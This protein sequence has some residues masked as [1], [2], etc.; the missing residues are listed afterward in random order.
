MTQRS[1]RHFFSSNMG[2]RGIP[3]YIFID[4]E[5]VSQVQ[6]QVNPGIPEWRLHELLLKEVRGRR[7]VQK[8]FVS[9]NL[10]RGKVRPQGVVSA[11]PTIYVLQGL[12]KDVTWCGTDAVEDQSVAGFP[13][14]PEEKKG[15]IDAHLFRQARTKQD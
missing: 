15:Y 7:Q 12:P 13:D 5:L 1:W 14:L 3:T 10:P 4:R 6:V 8:Q 11:A 2:G 9:K